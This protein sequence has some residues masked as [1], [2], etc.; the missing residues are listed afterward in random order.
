MLFSL[1]LVAKDVW[2]KCLFSVLVLTRSVL[3]E[4][5]SKLHVLNENAQRVAAATL[6]K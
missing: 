3:Q 2:L 5:F 1:S 6:S 4:L